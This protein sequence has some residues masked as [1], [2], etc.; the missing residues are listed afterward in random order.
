MLSEDELRTAFERVHE[1]IP[2]ACH[3]V[4]R[5]FIHAPGGWTAA[6]ARLGECD[7]E[8][9]KPLFDGLKREKFNLGEATLDFYSERDPEL[10]TDSERHYLERLSLRRATEAA[11]DDD[12]V[13]YDAHRDELRNDRKLKSVWNRFHLWCTK[14]NVRLSR[15]LVLPAWRVL[16]GKRRAP[17]AH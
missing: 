2:E 10:L 13:F 16:A 6:S 17:A 1:N 4:V 3:Q 7:S 9:I 12:R 15:G 14:G 5:D 11:L 8:D